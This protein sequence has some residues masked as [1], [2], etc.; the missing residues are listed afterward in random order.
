MAEDRRS[1]VA[2]AGVG[3]VGRALLELIVERALPLRLVGVADSKSSI[4]GDLD[5]QAIVAGKEH[6]MLLGEPGDLLIDG[7]PDVFVDV[8]S[9][10]FETGEPSLSTMLGALEAGISVVTA[11]KVPLARAWA[12]LW[13][14]ARASGCTIGYSA[15]AGAALPAVAVARALART[16]EVTAFRGVLT[17]TTTF[18][19]QKMGAGVAFADAVRMAQ[20]L[21]IAE[22]DPTVDIGGWDT[23]CKAVILANTLWDLDIDLADVSVRGIDPSTTVSSTAGKVCVVAEARV[24]GDTCNINVRPEGLRSH[25]PLGLLQGRDK[26]LVLEGPA[27]GTVTLSGGRS[28]P[29]GAA[30]AVLG[31]LLEATGR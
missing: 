16:G 31:D 12:K 14:A 9:C 13:A 3:G 1:R 30:A 6:G 22:P 7:R 18:V 28:H 19:L 27:I 25:D 21:G 8:M 11:N 2:V 24:V 10:D 17:G 15:A 23:A 26:G 5:P 29:R 4:V 20:E